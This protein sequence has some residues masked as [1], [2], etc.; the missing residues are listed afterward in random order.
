MTCP[1]GSCGSLWSQ[2]NKAFCLACSVHLFFECVCALRM[3]QS[4]ASHNTVTC[5]TTGHRQLMTWHLFSLWSGVLDPTFCC[6][7]RHDIPI[8]GK[9]C[10]CARVVHHCFVPLYMLSAVP[11]TMLLLC[12]STCPCWLTNTC[13]PDLQCCHRSH[14]LHRQSRCL[15]VC[16]CAVLPPNCQSKLEQQQ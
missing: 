9:C 2:V 11:F 15:P 14:W 8:S 3:Q 4:V 13:Q 10:L 1:H 16:G 7:Q 5:P 12:P 6:R